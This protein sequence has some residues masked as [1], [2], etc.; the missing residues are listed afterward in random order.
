MR[1]TLDISVLPSAP[2]D[3]D[4]AQLPWGKPF[5]AAI[6]YEHDGVGVAKIVAQ[7]LRHLLYELIIAVGGVSK[8]RG[9]HHLEL[10]VNS[11]VSPTSKP[12]AFPNADVVVLSENIFLS[13]VTWFNQFIEESS[14]NYKLYVNDKFIV[15]IVSLC[16][17]CSGGW[18]WWWV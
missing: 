5:G 4:Y 10:P 9:I 1:V 3:N 18:W 14:V 7:D 11:E 8:A 16:L 12:K 6:N 15:T 17:K 2:V 13:K